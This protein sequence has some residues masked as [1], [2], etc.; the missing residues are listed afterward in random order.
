[1]SLPAALWQTC[2]NK[3]LTAA[4]W[5]LIWLNDIF[6]RSLH[7]WMLHRRPF[8]TATA[9]VSR[10]PPRFSRSICYALLWVT[11]STLWSPTTLFYCTDTSLLPKPTG[12]EESQGQ[13]WEKITAYKEEED[14]WQTKPARRK[15][16]YATRVWRAQRGGQYGGHGHRWG[17]I[18]GDYG[19]SW[20]SKQ[21]QAR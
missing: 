17:Q 10:L 8:I 16:K 21:A 5:A 3:D 2:T 13:R 4:V 11:L 9:P 18:K 20:H 1:M 12:G 15:I 19:N 6:T 7:R 14:L